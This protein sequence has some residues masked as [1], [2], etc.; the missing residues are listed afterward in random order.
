V[1]VRRVLRVRTGRRIDPWGDP[2]GQVR[3]LGEPLA[4][5]QERVL[6]GCGRRFDAAIP[7]EEA[8]GAADAGTL[9][10]DDDVDV[11]PSAL[12][13]FLSGAG[14]EGGRMALVERPPRKGELEVE[15][16][17]PPHGGEPTRLLGLRVGG[18]ERAVVVPPKGFGGIAKAPG[19]FKSETPW[20][21]T[22]RSATTIAH[23]SHVLR[24]NMAAIPAAIDADIVRAPWNVLWAW[25][26]A[27]L[28]APGRFARIGRRC[29]IHPTA[30]LE[31]CVL[32]DDVEVG[33][34]SVLRGCVVGS[35]ARIEDH[36]TARGGVV[37]PGA[38]LGN[39]GMFNLSVLGARSS[40]SH[41][42][43]Q[44]CVVG[45]DTFVA[46]FATLQDLNLRGN[47]RVPFEGRMVDTGT[48]FLGVAV[49]HRVRM[50]AG[51]VV[52]A[53]RMV[54]N[55]VTLVAEP[56]GILSRVADPLAAGVY[57]VRDGRPDAL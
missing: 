53:G 6:R 48:P 27:P 8:A 31:L 46:T 10:W 38:H 24:A 43:A 50:G 56:G 52:A 32:G 30:R 41:I 19:P 51:T 5:R 9:L 39:Y 36:V 33:A 12:R 1:S 17:G 47:I 11:T 55:D 13:A 3:V 57:T 37:G 44:A 26:R 21:I 28:R 7:R 25:L 40:I 49:G 54:P 23:W 18:S 20:W 35:G 4:E 34:Y 14:T 45:D 29:R 2:V 22:A 16:P 15:P 42:G